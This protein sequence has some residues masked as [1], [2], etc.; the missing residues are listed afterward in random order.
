MKDF[1]EP[2]IVDRSTFEAE[3]DALRIRE[4]VHV[5]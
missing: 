4:K 5:R 1:A 3:L 2:D